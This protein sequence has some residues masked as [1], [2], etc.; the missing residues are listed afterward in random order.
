MPF[1]TTALT[2]G[3]LAAAGSIG[4]AAIAGHA[5]NK[6]ASAQEQGANYA[7]NLQ[8]QDAQDALKFQQ[9]QYSDEQKNAQPWLQAGTGAIN[10]LSGLLSPGGELTQGWNEQFQAPTDVTEQNDPGFQ[11]RLQQGEQALSNSAAA[12][13]GLLTGNTAKALNDYAQQDAS[14]EYGNVYNRAFNDYTTRYNQFQ[15]NQTNL[16]NRYAGLA[17]VGQQTASQ[18]AQSGQQAASNV[19]QIDLTSGQQIGNDYQNAAAARASGYVGSGN[20]YAGA[21]GN[22]LGSLS[23]LLLGNQLGLF[24]SSNSG[25]DPVQTNYDPSRWVN[26]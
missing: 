25:L 4:G 11:F 18:L 24:G 15:Q 17:G 26:Q 8:H 22:G 10:T 23:N 20:A 21:V 2:L 19:G 7:A 6:A 16:Y 13:G 9:Q 1:I 3:G 12:K 5:A 14:N